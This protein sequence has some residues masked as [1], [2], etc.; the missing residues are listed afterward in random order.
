MTKNEFL[1]LKLGTIVSCRFD[2]ENYF[3]IYDTDQMGTEYRGKRYSVYGAKQMGCDTNMVR[4]DINN[5]PFWK[6]EGKIK[7]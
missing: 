5:C 7:K 3:V 4:I 2:E 1:Q 6:I